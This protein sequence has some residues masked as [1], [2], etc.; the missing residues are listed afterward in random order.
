MKNSYLKRWKKTSIT[1]LQGGTLGYPLSRCK[2]STCFFCHVITWRGRMGG[3]VRAQ[4]VCTYIHAYIFMHT[5]IHIYTPTHTH[6]H[7]SPYGKHS[8]IRYTCLE[9]R[10]CRSS[11]ATV[12]REPR[13][14]TSKVLSLLT[15]FSQFDIPVHWLL[16]ICVKSLCHFCRHCLLMKQ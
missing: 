10:T 4:Y 16:R 12:S 3:L 14:A 8:I 13:R 2:E 11:T 6:T 1:S 7:R 15:F 9:P 5:Y